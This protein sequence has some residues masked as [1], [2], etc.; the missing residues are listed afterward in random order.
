MIILNP[1]QGKERIHR[2]CL[3]NLNEVEKESERERVRERW[4][5]VEEESLLLRCLPT[6]ESSIGMYNYF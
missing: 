2:V 6:S 1:R 3:L 5:G 4:Y